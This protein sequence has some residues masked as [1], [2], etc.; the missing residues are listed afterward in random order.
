MP[1]MGKNGFS[2]LGGS[3]CV[4]WPPAA[5][6]PALSRRGLGVTG[7]CCCCCCCCCVAS[8]GPNR[9]R[10]ALPRFGVNGCRFLGACVRNPHLPLGRATGLDGLVVV[11]LGRATPLPSSSSS[12]VSLRFMGVTD[13]VM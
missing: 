6:A 12:S 11:V 2:V 4:V 8:A 5:G 10:L 3:C 13:G 9:S 1:G 7:V